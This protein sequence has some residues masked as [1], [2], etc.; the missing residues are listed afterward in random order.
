MAAIPGIRT[1]IVPVF[2]AVVYLR[3]SNI[4]QKKLVMQKLIIAYWI[5]FLGTGI[6]TFLYCQITNGAKAQTAMMNLRRLST[7]GSIPLAI[8]SPTI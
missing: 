5:I 7:P 3:A 4:H 8:S 6:K 2:R 1:N